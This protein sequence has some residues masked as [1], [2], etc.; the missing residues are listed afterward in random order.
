MLSRLQ[1]LQPEHF[2][3]TEM[4]ILLCAITESLGFIYPLKIRGKVL[5][6]FTTVVIHYPHPPQE[7]RDNK[8]ELLHSTLDAG[9]KPFQA[10]RVSYLVKITAQFCTAIQIC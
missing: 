9:T 7:L 10:R 3:I 8:Y 1:S 5:F 2:L 6:L 4:L